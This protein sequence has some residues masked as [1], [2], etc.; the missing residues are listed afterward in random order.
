MKK[1]A[2]IYRL[3][4]LEDVWTPPG[5]KFEMPPTVV[6]CP[7]ID[8][9]ASLIRK[10]HHKTARMYAQYMGLDFI[11]FIHTVSALTGMPA[12]QWIN[13]FVMMDV[14]W[15][16]LNTYTNIDG[17]GEMC[18]FGKGD[19]LARAFRKFSGMSPTEFRK[20]NRVVHTKI[21]T[22]IELL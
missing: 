5:K 12:A 6:G 9:L 22:S 20:K 7:F 10:H 3:F 18:G 16:L 13:G 21:V 8:A 2:P 14:R 17:V 4:T 19:S 15:L 1:V 11:Q